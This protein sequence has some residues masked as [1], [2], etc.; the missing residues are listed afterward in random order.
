M[1]TSDF[2]GSSSHSLVFFGTLSDVTLGFSVIDYF[3]S[4]LFASYYPMEYVDAFILRVI[5][6]VFIRSDRSRLRADL[7][8]CNRSFLGATCSG[9]RTANFRLLMNLAR[10]SIRLR[11]NDHSCTISSGRR[12]IT[13]LQLRLLTGRI[14][15]LNYHVINECG[16]FLS[17][18]TFTILSRASL[19]STLKRINSHAAVLQV[20]AETRNGNRDDSIIIVTFNSF[21][22]L[23]GHLTFFNYDA[24]CFVRER[25]A[26]RTTAIISI[27][28]S[29]NTSVIID[30]RLFRLSTCAF[31]RLTDRIH[32]R[33]ITEIIRSGRRS[34]NFALRRL[35]DLRRALYAKDNG[36]ITRSETIRRA[37]TCRSTRY[38][39]VA[40]ATRDRSDRF[41]FTLQVNACSSIFA[42]WLSLIQ[43][44]RCVAF[45]RFKYCLFRVVCG[46][47]LCI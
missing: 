35:R 30:R 10:S 37:F 23:I 44:Y 22:R 21:S 34:A 20:H 31:Y 16:Q 14:C 15:R 5:S 9:L 43:V 13:D 4:H 39:F 36:S 24:W 6:V 32:A 7:F 42:A 45:R 28:A 17:T 38:K 3:V 8:L 40:K 18:A 25:A 1:A 41:I 19:R 12:L 46:F 11:I 33:R 29:A 27:N 26:N 47:Y 2:R